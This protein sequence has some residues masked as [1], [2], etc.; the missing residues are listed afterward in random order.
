VAGSATAAATTTV[1]SPDLPDTS[2]RIGV[3]FACQMVPRVPR[4]DHDEAVD[5]VVTEHAVYRADHG[6]SPA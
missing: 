6:A 2:V 1:S 4:A 3:C 5:L